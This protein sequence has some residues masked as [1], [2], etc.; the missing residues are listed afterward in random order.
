MNFNLPKSSTHSSNPA[1]A[2]KI[3][4]RTSCR[5]KVSARDTSTDM[6]AL[7]KGRV[8]TEVRNSKD[9]FQTVKDRLCLWPTSDEIICMLMLL[10]SEQSSPSYRTGVNIP[11]RP[12][13]QTASR[14]G[15]K[16]PQSPR[17]AQ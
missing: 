11:P 1:N 7:Q 9:V 5:P 3:K 15:R 14:K 4:R 12:V 16:T 13:T 2:E 8:M 6:S 17:T 10:K